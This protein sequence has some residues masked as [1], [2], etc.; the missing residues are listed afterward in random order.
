ML[1]Y[2]QI[3]KFLKN[4][5]RSTFRSN[6]LGKMSDFC[7]TKNDFDKCLLS[8]IELIRHWNKKRN[9]IIS[10]LNFKL[11]LTER[12]RSRNSIFMDR[13]Y[14]S[15]YWLKLCIKFYDSGKRKQSMKNVVLL[16]N[17]KHIES[18]SGILIPSIVF[19]GFKFWFYRVKSCKYLYPAVN[20]C[21]CLHL[22]RRSYQVANIYH[23]LKLPVVSWRYFSID[24]F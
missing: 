8:K 19:Y 15:A 1:Q 2:S 18:L 10:C 17:I 23:S 16:V 4:A 5:V 13:I 14:K 22:Y 20:F 3:H 7:R 9:F 6:I 11:E 24:Q 21:W 12:I